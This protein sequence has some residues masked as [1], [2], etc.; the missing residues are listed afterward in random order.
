MKPHSI[1]NNIWR[2]WLFPTTPVYT[3]PS[4]RLHT[5]SHLVKTQDHHLFPAQTF[6]DVTAKQRQGIGTINFNLLEIWQ[7]ETT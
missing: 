7:P 2:Q 5:F 1:G 6:K 4:K 3:D